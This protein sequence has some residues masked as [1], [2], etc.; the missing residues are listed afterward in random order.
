MTVLTAILTFDL[1]IILYAYITIHLYY[2]C[3]QSLIGARRVHEN[4]RIF[5]Y[6]YCALH[7]AISRARPANLT[8]PISRVQSY[9]FEYRGGFQ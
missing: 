4:S 8:T 2:N 6:N 7:C 3:A 9:E 5:C 1:Y